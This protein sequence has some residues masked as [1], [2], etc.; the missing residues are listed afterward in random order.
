MK[1][2]KRFSAVIICIIIA[3]SLAVPASA[4]ERN[5]EITVGSATAVPGDEIA[6]SV[7]TVKN[8]GVMAMTFALSYDNSVLEY[9]GYNEG[10]FNDY[11]V[12]DH[13]DNGYVSFVNCENKDRTYCGNIAVFLFKVKEKAAPGKHELKILNIRPETYGEDLTGC[14]ATWDAAK[15]SAKVSNGFVEVG[16][17]CSNMGHKFGKWETVSK[18]ICETVG[19]DARSC[20]KCGHTENREKKAL[21]HD[22]EDVWTIDVAATETE[23]GT[24]SRHCS[25]C[26]KA[27]DKVSF[28]LEVTKE[29]KIENKVEQT[30]PAQKWE[31]LEEQKNDN[32]N[33]PALPDGE[34]PIPDSDETVEVE[35]PED[36]TD[37]DGN[38]VDKAIDNL[39]NT[40]RIVII[41]V[42][43]ALLAGVIALIVVFFLKK[44]K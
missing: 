22:F 2:L 26:E 23:K 25:R 16:E 11:T 24:M 43:A 42:S 7:D 21:G 32:K 6:I 17:T 14:F 41:A 40:Q 20:T 9:Q 5:I 36:E 18:P 44:K 37:G 8:D 10:M 1:L 35:P 29:N 39:S 31:K 4:A 19:V 12:V 3:F 13:P 33:F 34:A 27:T 15:V 28:A 30:V 38:S